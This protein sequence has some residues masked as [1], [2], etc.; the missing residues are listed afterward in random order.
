ML[1][2]SEDTVNRLADE[3]LYPELE[4]FA[5]QQLAVG[6]GHTIHVEECGNPR[7]FPAVFLHGGPGSRTRAGHRRFF[8][9]QFYRIV[10]FDQR[11]CGRSTP[12]GRT[13]DN[14]TRHLVADIEAIRNHLGLDRVMVFGGSWGSTLALAYALAHPDRVAG[15][16][17]R[18]IFFGSRNEV[19]WYV[20][21]LRNFVP[22]A[23]EALAQGEGGSLLARYHGLVSEQADRR[24]LAAARR[25]VAYEEAIM[26]LDAGN[27]A[28]GPAGGAAD[29]LARARVQLH[30]LVHD[31]FLAP[32]ELASGLG[33]LD[34]VP[35]LIVQGR[36]DLVCPPRAAYELARL[37]PRAELRLVERGGHSAAA[38]E[39]AR[40]L[41]RAT[42]D[43]RTRLQS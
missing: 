29:V 31:C 33:R 7:G 38:P 3:P 32:G 23:W 12:L 11:G 17:L 27:K 25:W 41:R 16:V 5:V 9:P 43:M 20:D 39:I 2:P 8:D 35:A 1:P 42:D 24:A 40:A 14:T 34:G 22:E 30:Y 28:A 19:D 4:P 6:D 37:L 10:L 36:L 26:G 13:A 15:M 21:A 18:G